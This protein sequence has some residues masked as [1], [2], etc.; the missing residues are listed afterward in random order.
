M[1]I[2]RPQGYAE[3]IHRLPEQAT[4]PVVMA[5][6]GSVYTRDYSGITELC[7]E[8]SGAKI[9][10]ITDD[11]AVAG[12]TAP[13]GSADGVQINDGSGGF[14]SRLAINSSNQLLAA[15]GSQAAPSIV[16][17]SHTDTGIAWD[18]GSSGDLDFVVDG[19]LN[20]RLKN[21]HTSLLQPTIPLQGTP[22][23]PGL[24]L[25]NSF[26]AGIHSSGTSNF[27]T[28]TG[29][30]KAGWRI[31]GIGGGQ[32]AVHFQDH[33]TSPAICCSLSGG[34]DSSTFD[35]DSGVSFH[36]EGDNSVGILTNGIQRTL[37]GASGEIITA[38]G[39]ANSTGLVE[40]INSIQTTDATPSTGITIGLEDDTTY[41][42]E[43]FASCRDG[44]GTER[45]SYIRVAQAHRESGG[46]ATL[47][48]VTDI[49]TSETD[50]GFDFTLAGSGNNLVATCTGKAATTCSWSIHVKYLGSQ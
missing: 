44:A 4:A 14:G 8:D 11:G 32:G 10:Q 38:P 6:G 31:T 25:G 17:S 46:S 1:S 20:M 5:D 27:G 41:T 40:E 42:V 2:R 24:C 36:T 43:A 23:A 29:G 33:Q 7:Y 22:A 39:L 34:Y 13:G 3:P 49:F 26:S 19:A 9:T 35:F 21:N 47:T 30:I 28:A 50:A 45:A 48:G 18:I 37:W 15:D 16:S 12:A